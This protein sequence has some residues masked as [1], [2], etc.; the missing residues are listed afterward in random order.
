MYVLTCVFAIEFN[1]VRPTGFEPVTVCLEGRCSIQLSYE[2]IRLF[3]ASSLWP[4][5]CSVLGFGLRCS[6]VRRP[7]MGL[8]ETIAIAI[9]P[10]AAI[11]VIQRSSVLFGL[12]TLSVLSILLFVVSLFDFHFTNIIN[13]WGGGT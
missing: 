3:T 12:T 11:N 4:V 10:L 1:L 5:I 9:S 13:C 8:V 7:Y 2:R 6:F